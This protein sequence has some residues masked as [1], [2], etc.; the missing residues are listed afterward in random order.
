[1]DTVCHPAGFLTNHSTVTVKKAQLKDSHCIAIM[2]ENRY[3]LFTQR[4][5]ERDSC[6]CPNYTKPSP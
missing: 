1:M 4:L 3:R 6:T 2:W 5:H